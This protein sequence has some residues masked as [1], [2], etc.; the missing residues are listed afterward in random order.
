MFFQGCVV[1]CRSL[2]V[3]CSWVSDDCQEKRIPCSAGADEASAAKRA[4]DGNE[5]LACRILVH[6]RT[7]ERLKLLPIHPPTLFKAGGRTQQDFFL[8]TNLTL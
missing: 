1:V 5:A 2:H 7:G 4:S 6:F 8:E 3:V